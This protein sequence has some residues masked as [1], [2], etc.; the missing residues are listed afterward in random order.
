MSIAEWGF[1]VQGTAP[2]NSL[3]AAS[4][5]VAMSPVPAPG[6][7][8]LLGAFGLSSTRSRRRVG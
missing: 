2:H 8:L 5:D 7:L 3:D 1:L 6:A 4:V